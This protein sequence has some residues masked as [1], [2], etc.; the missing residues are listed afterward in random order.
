VQGGKRTQS[1]ENV[2]RREEDNVGKKGSR[3][4]HVLG[5]PFNNNGLSLNQIAHVK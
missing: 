3:A 2:T 4:S 5:D 1:K